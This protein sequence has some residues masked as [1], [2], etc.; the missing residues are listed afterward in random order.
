MSEVRPEIMEAFA[1]GIQCV[2]SKDYEGLV[3]AFMDTGFVGT[4]IEH[5]EVPDKD[6]WSPGDPARLARELRE[7]MEAAQ[8]DPSRAKAFDD[9]VDKALIQELMKPLETA[10]KARIAQAVNLTGGGKQ[11]QRPVSRNILLGGNEFMPGIKKYANQLNAA[12]A[13]NRSTSRI[14]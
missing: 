13:A 8:S 14:V 2:L 11:S 7:A 10:R 9:P 5:R 6:P 12:A 1:S 4:P 3:K